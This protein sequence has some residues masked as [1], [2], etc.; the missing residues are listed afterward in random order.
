M[1]SKL[2]C[3]FL[4]I[5]LSLPSYGQTFGEILNTLPKGIVTPVAVKHDR[6][7]YAGDFNFSSLDFETCNQDSAN[8]LV[9]FRND[10]LAMVSSIVGERFDLH[11]HYKDTTTYATIILWE[12]DR[13]TSADHFLYYNKTGKYFILLSYPF[14]D[15]HH[16]H[17]EDPDNFYFSRTHHE[18]YYLYFLNE[19]LYPEG[20]VF[21][22]KDKILAN[23]SI[24]IRKGGIEEY[25]NVFQLSVRTSQ[26]RIESDNPNILTLRL[27]YKIGVFT[28][29]GEYLG[30]FKTPNNGIINWMLS[31]P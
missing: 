22:V 17:I 1:A 13:W 6:M 10:S 23:S 3:I 12:D 30:T 28:V 20:K 15:G 18:R 7:E 26:F 11:F 27:L 16:A 8:Y 19:K 21:V 9:Y 29:G 25:A 2:F 5:S 4:L 31:P 14:C 24:A